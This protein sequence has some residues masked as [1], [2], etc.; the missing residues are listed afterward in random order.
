MRVLSCYKCYRYVLCSGSLYAVHTKV[1][2]VAQF[3]FCG[4]RLAVIIHVRLAAKQSGSV[5]CTPP[6]DGS[7]RRRGAPALLSADRMIAVR[8][9]LAG[10][11]N[12]AA[13]LTDL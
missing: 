7:G 4:E 2:T 10:E 3:A 11:L 1:A 8:I 6:S 12:A 13:A 9:R 5:R